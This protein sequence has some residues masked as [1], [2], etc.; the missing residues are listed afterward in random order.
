MAISHDDLPA[1]RLPATVAPDGEGEANLDPLTHEP[2]AHPVGVG[3]G[4]AGVGTIGAL[5]GSVAGPVGMLVGTIAGAFAGA[6]VGKDTAEAVNPT[7][8]TDRTAAAAGEFVAPVLPPSTPPPEPEP[9]AEPI[10]SSPAPPPPA[11]ARPRLQRIVL[12]GRAAA[13]AAAATPGENLAPLEVTAQDAYPEGGVREAAYFRY[14]ERQRSGSP[15]NETDDWTA[16]EREV[17]RG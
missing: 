2:G 4:A 7:E 5:L 13:V 11:P 8:G 17:L 12:A 6:V 1:P 15:G 3:V 16:A 10:F 14:L 9:V